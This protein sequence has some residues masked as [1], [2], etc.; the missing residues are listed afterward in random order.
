MAVPDDEPTSGASL[1]V[2]DGALDEAGGLVGLVRVA[3]A[4]LPVDEELTLGAFLALAAAV[5]LAGADTAEPAEV[6]GPVTGVLDAAG[7]GVGVGV[8]HLGVGA[9]PAVFVFAAA[10]LEALLELEPLLGLELALGL[11]LAVLL[12]LGLELAVLLAL[13]LELAVPLV[14]GLGPGLGVP[15]GLAVPLPPLP[16]DGT[17]RELA[18][19]VCAC[20]VALPDEPDAAGVADEPWAGGQEVGLTLGA[21][22]AMLPDDIAPPVVCGAAPWPVV[23]PVPPVDADEPVMA[24]LSVDPICPTSARAAGTEARTTPTVN[25]VR[26]VAKA[27]RSIAS[28]QSRFGARCSGAGRFRPGAPAQEAQ[29]GRPD[30]SDPVVLAGVGRAR[31][32]LLAD[33]LQAVGARFDLIRGSVKLAPQ[34]LAEVLPAVEAAARSHHVSC[35]SDARSAA[36]PRAVWL[37]TAPRLIFIAA[38]ISASEKS[39]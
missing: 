34:E 37:L 11:G 3:P 29:D 27:G 9:G 39:A 23:D 22:P 17:A 25:T 10:E 7:A 2:E 38:A 13:G 33:L 30:G 35:S 26:P 1:E 16:L 8:V 4:E 18:T 21:M 5:D 19:L 6:A 28:R 15:L 12:A 14:P 32:D 36:M 24:E 20:V 31:A